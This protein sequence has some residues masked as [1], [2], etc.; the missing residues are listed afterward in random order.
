MPGRS[1]L[2]KYDWDLTDEEV[3]R[4]PMRATTRPWH[5]VA[6]KGGHVAL[7]TTDTDNAAEDGP[8]SLGRPALAACDS[9]LLRWNTVLPALVLTPWLLALGLFV[10]RRL[11]DAPTAPSGEAVDKGSVA[12][13]AARSVLSVAPPPPPAPPPA[14][15]PSPAPP[16]V[17][18]PPP[19]SPR[20]LLC[21]VQRYPDLLTGFCKNALAR[22]NWAMLQQHW[23]TAGRAEGR[24]FACIVELPRPPPPPKPPRPPPPPM[25]PSLPPSPRPPPPRLPPSPPAPPPATWLGVVAQLNAQWLTGRPASSL[26]DAGVVMRVFDAQ[27][28]PEVPWLPDP[29]SKNGDHFAT[30]IVNLKQ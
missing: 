26:A 4:K 22:C 30:S 17:P 1:G 11:V 20:D 12:L 5:S 9:K 15:P 6:R 16:P 25:P 21:Y 29:K 3:Q 27:E 28:R 8:S 24:L 7:S 13:H 10:E 23:D 19:A 14:L 2:V 18:P